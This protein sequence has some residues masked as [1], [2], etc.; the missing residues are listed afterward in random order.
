MLEKLNEKYNQFC[1]TYSVAFVDCL[2]S[3]GRLLKR[4]Y[5]RGYRVG[6]EYERCLRE[7]VKDG[8]NT[9]RL[10]VARIARLKAM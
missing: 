6:Y 8:L 4:C 2:E 3:V 7:C 9:G 10:L 1:L 5:R